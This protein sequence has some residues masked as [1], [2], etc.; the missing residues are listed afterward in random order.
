MNINKKI[1][2]ETEIA[3]K[4][5]VFE[6]GSWAIQSNMA[7]KASYG[8]TVMLITAVSGSLNPEI[9]FFPLTVN[10]TEK[11][12]ATG[13]IKSSRFQKRD[14]RSTDEMIMIGRATDHAIR[15]LFP[16]DFR[17]D[18]QVTGSVLS[19][20]AE[21]DPQ[22]LFMNAVSAALLASDIPWAGP[23]VSAKVGYING[24]YVLNPT[25]DQI[26][27]ESELVMVV[28]FVGSDLKFL[29]VEAEAHEL[30]EA[31]ILGAIE[32]ARNNLKDLMKFMM[33]FAE[34]VNP[35]N[36][37]FEYISQAVDQE[38]VDLVNAMSKD[39]VFELMARQ[40]TK[41]ELSPLL[42]ELWQEIWVKYEGKYKKA[43]LREAFNNLEK[44]AL[45]KMILDDGIRPD[46]RGI[47]DVRPIGCEI[48][49]LPRAHGSGFFSRGITQMLT[50]VTLGS[51]S[52]ELLVQDTYGEYTRR[53]MHFYSFPPYSS[54][55]TGRFGG[56]PKNRE[57]GHGMLAENALKPV[58][59]DQDVFP[60]TIIVNSE[61]M[62]SS[63]STSMA[64]TCASTLALMDAGVPIKA[65]VA[66]VGVGL[67][68][69]DD[70]SKQLIMTDLAYLEDAYGFLDFKMTG[71]RA[72]VTAIQCDMKATGIPMDLV[73]KIIEQSKEGR[74]HVLDEM[75]KLIKEPKA[76]V[77]KYAPKMVTTKID[78]SD[79]G[80]VI[81]AGGKT[82]RS[83]QEKTGAEIS[84]EEDGTVVATSLDEADAI[85]AISIIENMLKDITAGE[86]YDG[87]VVELLDFGALVEILPG[88][89]GLVHVSELANQFVSNVT[90]VVSVGDTFKVK[91]LD[92]DRRTGKISL[93]KKALEEGYEEA[94]RRERSDRGGDRRDDRRGGDRGSNRNRGGNFNRDR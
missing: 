79:I 63:G 60:Y 7:I 90:D 62:S 80:T 14:F 86:V 21:A 94:P 35:S 17:N 3:G 48:G 30:P 45:Q 31:K 24:E 76:T 15:P 2:K 46:G 85:E 29:A 81:G 93:S 34:E 11:M 44:H 43:K 13:S 32:F 64:A 4:K 59:P 58:I 75:E 77:S 22:F 69:N 20:D 49:L 73:P 72:G 41:E 65:M 91:V 89:V 67:I 71:T 6:V 87:T 92:S 27:N 53:Y 70:M 66:G 5:L 37:K 56:Y 74:M 8:D 52:M 9:D 54:G 26:R 55:E 28:S 68:V 19:L 39:K 42:D 16:S 88:K 40:L 33:E 25:L 82:I 78:P 83:I 12:F 23:A 50:A 10:Y 18:T 47:K 84:I 57:I 38:I 61:T 36:T 1:I 51:P